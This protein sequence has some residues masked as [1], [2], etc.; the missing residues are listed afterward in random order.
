MKT[1]MYE[2]ISRYIYNHKKMSAVFLVTVLLSVVVLITVFMSMSK[3]AVSMTES[4]PYIS[5]E[6]MSTE[7]GNS[8]SVNVKAQG[9]AE[10]KCFTLTFNG[11]CAGLSDKY[12]FNDDQTEI[13]DHSGN[14]LILNRETGGDGAVNY[15]FELSEGETHIFTLDCESDVYVVTD[16]DIQDYK[17]NMISSENSEELSD[18]EITDIIKSQKKSE[19]ADNK[20]ASLT[21]VGGSGKD[22]DSAKDD[23]ARQ[24]ETELSWIEKKDTQT[25]VKKLRA[26]SQ[27]EY[28]DGGEIEGT[29]L[30]WAYTKKRMA[31]KGTL[32]I[33]GSGDLPNDTN[34]WSNYAKAIST[35]VIGDDVTSIG[36]SCFRSLGATNLKLGKSLTTIGGY[37]F[38]Y[39]N[40][41]EVVFPES[42]KSIGAWA[43]QFCSTLTKVT[44]HEGLET[45]SGG[46][47]R[48][49]NIKSVYIPST[50]KSISFSSNPIEEYIVNENNTTYYSDDGILFKYLSDGTSELASYPPYKKGDE[51]TVPENVSSIG[52]SAFSYLKY[53][54]RITVPNTVPTL[55]KGQEFYGAS[56]LEE[57]IFGDSVKINSSRAFDNG[58]TNLK[59]IV[60][61]E[62]N[63]SSCFYLAGAKSLQE[64]Y[65]AVG[66][67]TIVDYELSSSTPSLKNLY[68]DAQHA[69]YFQ[70]QPA[71]T[72][73]YELTI[74]KNVDRLRNEKS[75]WGGNANGFQSVL[76]N[77]ETVKFV[78]PNQITI[79][80][81]VFN[82]VPMPAPLDALVGTVYVDEQGVVYKYDATTLTASVAYV[83]YDAENI[84][85]PAEITPESDVTCKINTVDT[86][87]FKLAEKLTSVSFEQ[88]ENIEN[89][90][91]YGF[92]YAQNLASVNGK[93]TEEEAESSFTNA[94][95]GYRAFEYTALG[96]ISGSGSFSENMNGQK[97]LVVG[98]L[99]PMYISFI[100]NDKDEG[101]LE[102][103]NGG[104]K[105]LTGNNISVSISVGN[106]EQSTDSVYRV[107]FETSELDNLLSISPGNTIEMNGT[108]VTC[109]STDVPNIVYIDFVPAIGQTATISIES[110]YPSPSSK[111]GGLTV[112]G[113]ILTQEQAE[114]NANKIIECPSNV[115]EQTGATTLSAIQAY[116][117]T[118]SDDFTLAKS[119]T[120]STK[121]NIVG[122]GNGNL[123]L[124]DNISYKIEQKRSSSTTSAYGKDYVRSV[125]FYDYITLPEQVQWKPEVIEC[126]KSG[127]TRAVSNYI[128][129]GDIT[130][131]SVSSYNANSFR[132]EWNEELQNIVF[133]W[134][135]RNSSTTAEIGN[136]SVSLTLHKGSFDV[137]SDVLNDTADTLYTV[138][139]DV[140][141]VTH[142]TYSSDVEDTA[143]VDK[144]FSPLGASVAIAKSATAATYFGE[145]IQYTI[146]LY[147]KG[148]AVYES[149][150]GN[151]R[152]SDAMPQTIYITPENMDRM[153][154]DTYGKRLTLTITNAIFGQYQNVTATDGTEAYITPANTTYDDAETDSLVISWNDDQTKLQITKS[155]DG[156][157][158][159]VDTSLSE[160][161]KNMGYAIDLNTNFKT[162]WGVADDDNKIRLTGGQNNYYYIYATIKDTFMLLNDDYP[163][164]YPTAQIANIKN[165]AYLMNGNKGICYNYV[166]RTYKR[167]AYI[168]KTAYLNETGEELTDGLNAQFGDVVDYNIEF[169]HY[170]TGKYENLP[171][172]DDIFG[173]QELLVPVEANPSLA[174]EELK[175]TTVSENGQNIKYYILSKPGT[176]RNIY[177]GIDESGNTMLADTITVNSADS[178][179]T[180]SAGGDSY[181]YSGLHTKILWYYS[182]LEPEAYYLDVSYHTIVDKDLIK[183]S[184][185]SIGNIAWMN[186][187]TGD[188]IYTALWG[189]GSLLTSNKEIVTPNSDGTYTA[190]DDGYS[191]VSKGE[192]VYYRLT[193]SNPNDYPFTIT[194][195]DISDE[196]PVTMNE[197]DWTKENVSLIYDSTQA[198]SVTGLD[199]WEI[200]DK[201]LGI[202]REGHYYMSWDSSMKIV[203]PANDSFV[204]Y[205]KLDFPDNDDSLV[206]SKYCDAVRGNKISNIFY[207]YKEEHTVYHSLKETGNVL[208]QKGVYGTGRYISNT[209]SETQSRIYYNN[210]DS[211]YRMVSYYVV[212]YN[213]GNSRLYLDDIYDLLP[214]G[215]TFKSLINNAVFPD[216][217][218]MVSTI[219]TCDNSDIS[220]SPLISLNV[221]SETEVRY[222][223]AS[224]TCTPDDRNLTFTVSAG[225][226]E[227]AIQ[228][229]ETE[230]KYFLEK[231]DAL[232]FGYMCNT[233]KSSESLD[234]ARNTVTMHYYDYLDSGVNAADSSDVS[235][236]G[237]FT[238]IHTDQ[239]DGS[240]SVKESEEISTLF[241]SATSGKWLTSDVTVIRGGIIPG[242]TAYTDSY[243]ND[244]DTTVIPYKTSVGPYATINW[245]ARLHNS[246]KMSITDY[247]FED[248]LPA[249]YSLTGKISLNIYESIDN[250]LVNSFA[251]FASVSRK[252]DDLSSVT[253][254]TNVDS[255]TLNTNGEPVT[256]S[257]LKSSEIYNLGISLTRSEDGQE[258]LSINFSDPIFSIPEDNGYAEIT[259]SSKNYSGKFKNTVY[260]NYVSFIPN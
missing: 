257:F 53:A 238:Y 170:G 260:T 136:I 80:E 244:Q 179:E 62:N 214:E 125:E 15:W 35:I 225:T 227:Y 87:A 126:I 153:F 191:V 43:F 187:K 167:E 22:L 55:S 100:N 28:I 147:N 152:I 110:T 185:Y 248:K 16:F 226:G 241:P 157:I 223:N 213:N 148:A 119:S 195:N 149:E 50:V 113:T 88:P 156:S 163:G 33:S 144:Y 141:S 174:D 73:K 25:T 107:Y 127:N 2:Q 212:L 169:A 70:R 38:D 194:G 245:R 112:W 177:V 58:C 138:H 85:I 222:R 30:T 249:P 45:V 114:E 178:E 52:A 60:L 74:G 199:S 146:R 180:V 210:N 243:I 216:R 79:D 81:H 64:L 105:T 78:G 101:M 143:D 11:K 102:W 130:V 34:L 196:L 205:V 134:K 44:F 89:I 97:S 95:I 108:T 124:A 254:T 26:S 77:A 12:I 171:L 237:S 129:A 94:K 140:R 240:C 231:N 218:D 6:Y 228:Y 184:A 200:T 42:L 155:S 3:P 57:V 91:V 99:R 116:W 186:N 162:E 18:N 14:S 19:N 47:F 259:L 233:G 133:Y 221:P 242:V 106:I 68:F 75:A 253:V 168:S 252:A 31:D 190:D 17:L 122:D 36:S 120:G 215:F 40:F 165:N 41:S 29:S 71:R 83:P 8:L 82:A 211:S 137:N 159:E 201:F 21:I 24:S 188:R 236:N 131:A 151:Y 150:E 239:N 37:S 219:K 76:K 154:N 251:D 59:R 198:L 173:I 84:V 166:L 224:I 256:I 132:A 5:A 217:S 230:K 92:A 23:T 206:W 160:T 123:V 7:Y 158:V 258:I 66:T 61:H 1:K 139:N 49:C 98:D 13:T 193:L 32:T 90:S 135:S 128:Y 255:Y 181:S 117:T 203:I 189:N 182:S 9:T 54:K 115:D 4:N 111:G 20:T 232:V 235:V 39:N 93:T 109:Y 246:G 118:V 175:T 96:G 145:D 86:Y 209:H 103:G 172:V 202:T 46:A 27:E 207:V 142:F 104:Y 247:T 220:R 161:L 63:G 121:I 51:Y 67:N 65:I 48:S 197:F 204:M 176:Y 234:F 10:K 72:E 192:S 183:S 69:Y 208:I 229:D 164:S 250:N 56:S